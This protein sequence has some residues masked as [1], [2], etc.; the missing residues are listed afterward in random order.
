MALSI[1]SITPNFGPTAGNTPITIVGT[2][3][4]SDRVV[5]LVHCD[6]T[7]GSTTF[8][9]DSGF[10]NDLTAM[11][12]AH[13]ET[14]DKKFGTAS[15]YFD[16]T[17][18]YLILDNPNSALGAFD[19][20]FTLECWVQW[21]TLPTGDGG[22][23]ERQIMGQHQWPESLASGTWW[24]WF[25]IAS[26]IVF[27]ARSGGSSAS[28]AGSWAWAA[29]IWYH[30]A[31]VKKGSTFSLYANGSRIA[32][33][34]NFTRSIFA[35]DSRAFTIGADVDGNSTQSHAYFD[36]IRICKDFAAYAGASFDLPDAE[37]KSQV[38]RVTIDGNQCTNVIVQST[39]EIT[40]NT[41]PGTVGSKD[42]V[43]S[44]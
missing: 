6:G 26:G 39:T 17:G 22:G 35:D 43:L 12:D 37:H 8:T 10:G 38:A 18:D 31:V 25:G 16:G 13:I 20:D 33:D 14:D 40:A 2:D 23:N 1:T 36:D 7:D 29:N 3:F 24:G 27:Y 4:H 34:T 5:M 11:G 30:V 44:I 28:L 19:S 32:E 21:K 42:V 9:D 41:P 15:A